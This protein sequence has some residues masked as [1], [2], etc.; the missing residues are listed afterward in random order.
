MVVFACIRSGIRLLSRPGGSARPLARPVFAAMAALIALIACDGG[1]GT[2]PD[3]HEG[4]LIV[5]S[6]LVLDRYSYTGAACD[7]VAPAGTDDIGAL[8][9]ESAAHLLVVSTACYSVSVRIEDT[10]GVEV[11]TLSRRFRIHGRQDGDKDRG[12]E[13]WIAWDGLDRSGDPLPPAPYLWRMEFDF[14]GG[15]ILRYRADIVLFR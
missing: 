7:E 9:D 5:D 13:G 4:S 15:R 1:Q 6:L 11:D 8:P 12:V 10:L 14:G 3:R 2:A